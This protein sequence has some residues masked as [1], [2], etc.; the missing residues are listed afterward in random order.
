[1]RLD[2]AAPSGCL[3]SWDARLRHGRI[4]RGPACARMPDFRACRI[5][6]DVKQGLAPTAIVAARFQ[7]SA[8][9]FPNVD[10]VPSQC[11]AVMFQQLRWATNRKGRRS[12]AS[13]TSG[14]LPA[15]NSSHS[16]SLHSLCTPYNLCTLYSLCRRGALSS[17]QCVSTPTALRF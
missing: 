9:M 6:R 13:N 3:A 8:L 14:K 1:M 11:C 5:W 10:G 12:A 4:C 16:R 17:A 7:P 2:T 15:T